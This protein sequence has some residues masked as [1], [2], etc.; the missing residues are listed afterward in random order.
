MFQF[1]MDDDTYVTVK[2]KQDAKT[3]ETT[4]VIYADETNGETE[5]ITGT[6]RCHVNDQWNP[7]LGK[8]HALASALQGFSKE[9]ATMVWNAF[10]TWIKRSLAKRNWLAENM[11][12]LITEDPWCFKTQDFVKVGTRG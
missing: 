12:R 4:A 8:K 6:V 10:F 3:R 9:R 1:R 2:F 7:T 5:V 11:D